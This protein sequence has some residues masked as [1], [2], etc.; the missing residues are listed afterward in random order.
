MTVRTAGVRLE[1][2]TVFTVSLDPKALTLFAKAF[3][4]LNLHAKRRSS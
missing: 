3:V 2:D 4:L 1:Q